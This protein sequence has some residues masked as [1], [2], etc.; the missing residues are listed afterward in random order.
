LIVGGIVLFVVVAS[1][2][3]AVRTAADL[4]SARRALRGA[5]QDLE[6]DEIA[7]AR[8]AVASAS[9]RLDGVLASTVGVVP[10]VGHNLRALEAV[11]DGAFPVLESAHALRLTADEIDEQ[12]L[13]ANG[14]VRLELIERMQ[15]PL[16]EEAEALEEMAEKL[17]E[18]RS[19]L[20]LP[21]VY[22]EMDEL[23]DRVRELRS[24]ATK[25]AAASELAP[26]MLGRDDPRTYLVL[27]INNV[28]LR[29]AGGILSG[30]GTVTMSNGGIELGDFYPY[31][32]LGSDPYKPVAAPDGFVERFGFALAHT[33]LFI[34]ATYS[35]EVPD[36]AV[37]V[38]RLF[39]KVK[40]VATDGAI[41]V[42]PRGVAALM[43]PNAEVDAPSGGD[44]DAKELPKYIYTTA[45]EE[46][47]GPRDARRAALLDVGRDAFQVLAER[48]PGG[49]Q[50]LDG[51]A[52]AVAGGHLR[53]VSF[54]PA[55]AEVLEDMGAS[56]AI[57]ESEDSVLVT[58]QNQGADKLDFYVRR[59]VEHRCAIED[60]EA[61]CETRATLRNE[62]PNGLT[63]YVSPR[64]RNSAIEFLEVYVPGTAD[65]TSVERDGE[66][67]RFLRA[68]QGDRVSFGADVEIDSGE[69]TSLSVTYRLPL[70]GSY[71]LTMTPQP[72]THDAEVRVELDAP[73]DW[74]VDAPD[75]SHE[76]KV[77][78]EDAFESTLTFTAEPSDK[79]GLTSLW[80]G[81][82]DFWSDQLF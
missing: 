12:D 20:L 76:E 23:L 69:R 13:V 21:P 81:L 49:V 70:E 56:G 17:R 34:N 5:V 63:S 68:E 16:E 50:D 18:G 7:E 8:D 41:L 59:A 46:L 2:Y 60:D 44:L 30:L 77:I 36:V 9:D 58:V 73:S 79:S 39:E 78:Y 61:L 47:G 72:L 62:A 6:A 31:A 27:L 10:V 24:S 37:V 26:D 65:V 71:E 48:G 74:T 1:M 35:P 82:A 19:S 51:L 25:A 55:E 28:E 54:D 64:P 80:D 32:K 22:D 33:T 57:P 4:L 43:P 42:D 11:A 75:G 3:L 15:G 45:Y 66:P 38:A 14:R 52:E 40:N 53:F 67:A 29:G